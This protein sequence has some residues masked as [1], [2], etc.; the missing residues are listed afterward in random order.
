MSRS[1]QK[2]YNKHKNGVHSLVFLGCA[3]VLGI[4]LSLNVL[5]LAQVHGPSMENTLK[6]NQIVL[7]WQLG[8]TP[9]QGDVVVADVKSGFDVHLVKRVIAVGGQHIEIKGGKLYIDGKLTNE[10]Y[11]KESVWQSPDLSL[12]LPENTVFLMGDNRNHSK[13]SRLLGY[14]SSEHIVG[15][16]LFH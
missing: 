8:Y 15:K 12:T 16:V 6:D 4:V 9:Q 14:V 1:I 3:A 2:F 7:V 11:V 10:S 5:R 13:D